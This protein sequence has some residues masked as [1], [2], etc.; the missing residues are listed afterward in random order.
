MKALFKVSRFFEFLVY[1]LQVAPFGSPEEAEKM[2][3]PIMETG[4]LQSNVA[5]SVQ[6]KLVPQHVQPHKYI[7]NSI[8]DCT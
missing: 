2:L 4:D 1:F 5:A 3:L 8:L 7:V 6:D